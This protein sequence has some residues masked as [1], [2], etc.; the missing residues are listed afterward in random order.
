MRSLFIYWKVSASQAE[1]A[2]AAAR[3]W[4][5]QLCAANQGLR[6]GLYRRAPASAAPPAV[7]ETMPGLVT[8]ME[9][10][11]A[12]DGVDAALEH[13]IAAAGTAGLQALGAPQRHFEAFISA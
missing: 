3:A 2:L 10:Y 6:A 9:T 11:A 13:A 12:P 4:Q 1:A 8:V 7:A 5:A